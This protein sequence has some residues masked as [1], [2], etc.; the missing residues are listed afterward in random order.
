MIKLNDQ[1]SRLKENHNRC[2]NNGNL[3]DFLD[4][5]HTLRI[6]SEY[7]DKINEVI[8]ND[9]EF[10]SETISKELNKITKK[11]A[12]IILPV[13]PEVLIKKTS[14]GNIFW[15]SEPL[16]D[17]EMARITSPKHN[18]H[19]RKYTFES[20]WGSQI[21]F[22]RRTVGGPMIS[23]NRF[24]LVQRT[25]NTLG[26]S[27]I[28][29]SPDKESNDIDIVLFELYKRMQILEIPLPFFGCYKIAQEILAMC[30]LFNVE[31]EIKKLKNGSC[32]Q[33]I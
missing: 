13:K 26:A 6:F 33:K 17:K 5:A 9:A 27:H 7:R 24:D 23:I 20:F 10:E 2:N 4:L 30:G 32:Q 18:F 22:T 15:I 14:I 21:I 16:P 8:V 19:K 3:T 12:M 11:P 29:K 1:L 28:F 31:E 25:A